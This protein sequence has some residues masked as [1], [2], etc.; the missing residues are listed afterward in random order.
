MSRR[1]AAEKREVLP[2]G[3][4]YGDS[5]FSPNSLNNLKIDGKKIGA[6]RIVT[7]AMNRDLKDRSNRAPSKFST[8]RW[9]NIKPS[10]EVRRGR[11]GGATYSGPC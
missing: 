9:D 11:V 5:W 10:V 4:E 1:H 2:D 8:K 6:E 3:Q 7:N